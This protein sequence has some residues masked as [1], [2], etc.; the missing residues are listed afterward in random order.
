MKIKS[1]MKDKKGGFTDL[2]IFMIFAFIIAVVCVIFVYMGNTTRD[3][4]QYTL[5][6]MTDL[7]DVN[8]NNASVVIDNTFGTGI[9]S[10][11]ALRWLSVLIIFG[12]II[13]IFIGSYLVTTKPV[14]FIP[15]IFVLIIAVVVSVPIANSYETLMGDA[16]LSGTF[17]QFT[18]LNFIILNLP[19]FVTIIGFVGAIIAA[20]INLSLAIIVV[21][22][23]RK[24]IVHKTFSFVS[25]CLFI[26]NLFSAFAIY[27]GIKLLAGVPNETLIT[28]RIDVFHRLNS[29]GLVFLP[30]AVLHFVISFTEIRGKLQKYLL[31]SWHTPNLWWIN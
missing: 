17:S 9:Q 14:F 22:M 27:F 21:S 13:S 6:N 16:T 5:G 29:V 4:L 1:L 25:I 10:Y 11:N 3:Q 28:S 12:M 15:Y 8:D 26:W 7:R 31:S 23:N 2:L 20:S 24:N 30:T 18:G 19:I